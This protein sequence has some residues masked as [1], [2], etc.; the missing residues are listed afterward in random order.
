MKR[1]YLA[2]PDVFFSDATERAKL[3]KQWVRDFGFKPLHPV[4]QEEI[5]ASSI[6]HHNIRLLDQADAVLANI[7]PF[8]GAEID[9]G[10]AFEIGY[11]VAQGLPVFTYRSTADTVLDTVR[12]HYSPVVL[13]PASRI[14][15]DRN[16]ALIEDFGLPSN[17]MV[18][19]STE[20][21]HGTFTDALIA[22]QDYFKAIS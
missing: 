4:D 2:G 14:W 12:E 10:T 21:V 16:G 19:I 6:Y 15:R 7:T 11:A 5:E 3:H 17:L 9:T 18:A 13:D 8:R 20:F 1:I 22:A